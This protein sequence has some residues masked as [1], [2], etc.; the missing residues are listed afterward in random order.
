MSRDVSEAHTAGFGAEK[1]PPWAGVTLTD[2]FASTV[3]LNGAALAFA[4]PAT[5]ANEA[6]SR[7]LSYS[8]ADHAIERVRHRIE[9]L[10]LPRNAPLL[11]CFGATVEAPIS[12]LAC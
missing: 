10:G 3:Q 4:G 11:M 1:T 6:S 9:D 5:S 12:I 2:L 8:E 7:R